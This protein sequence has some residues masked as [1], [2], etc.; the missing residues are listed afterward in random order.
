[1]NEKTNDEPPVV[2]TLADA[3]DDRFRLL[4]EAV[5]DYGIFMLDPAGN[6]FSWNPGAEK[7]NGY[8]SQEII[9]QHFSCLYTAGA[10]T[11]KR[12]QQQVLSGR[13]RSSL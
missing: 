2:T 4:V 1:M 9:G 11:L 12:R 7:S 13:G 8:K 6:V 10:A 5:H 3:V